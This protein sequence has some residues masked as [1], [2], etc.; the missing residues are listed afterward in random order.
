MEVEVE[1]EVE[2]EETVYYIIFTQN[3]NQ[4]TIKRQTN[5]EPSQ[6]AIHLI[7]FSNMP[8]LDMIKSTIELYQTRCFFDENNNKTRI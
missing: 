1:V 2:V 8:W 4:I 3:P 5:N 7:L 6:V